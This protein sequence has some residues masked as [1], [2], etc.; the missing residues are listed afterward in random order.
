MSIATNAPERCESVGARRLIRGRW[1]RE[2]RQRRQRLAE[3][4]QRDLWRLLEAARV[5]TTPIKI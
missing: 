1:S 2:E 3:G 5:Q 4:K